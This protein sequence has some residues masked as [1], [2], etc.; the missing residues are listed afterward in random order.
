MPRAGGRAGGI[1][2]TGLLSS[3]MVHLIPAPV[4]PRALASA[5]GES[6]S[7]KLAA[8]R[9]I[10]IY[11]VMGSTDQAARCGFLPGAGRPREAQSGSPASAAS[12]AA[13]RGRES[14]SAAAR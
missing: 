13:P 3:D 8:K 7:L 11:S 10:G 1:V 5:G 9:D 4:S 6:P 2:S 14:G 12:P